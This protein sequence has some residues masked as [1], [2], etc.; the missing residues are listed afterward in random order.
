MNR[1]LL[2]TLAIT[3]GLM[4]GCASSS[5]TVNTQRFAY[6]SGRSIEQ[7][8]AAPATVNPRAVAS[9]EAAVAGDGISM[10]VVYFDFDE[11][12]VKPEHLPMINEVSN[13]MRASP[14]TRVRLE[15]HTDRHGSTE[16]NLALGQRRAEAVR[17]LM[18]LNGVP[19]AQMDAVSFGKEKPVAVEFNAEAD[20]K[21]RRTEI[22]TFR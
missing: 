19:E 16:Y 13:A 22:K 4:A 10:G 8:Q 21:N 7:S 2:S 17:R 15:G 14:Q 3:M 18:L 5:K 9:V 6:T 12:V 20:A 11:Y 1:I